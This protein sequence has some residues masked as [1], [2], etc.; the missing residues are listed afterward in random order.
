[1]AARDVE[2]PFSFKWPLAQPSSA[3][4]VRRLTDAVPELGARKDSPSQVSA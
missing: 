3:T 4:A 1:M 2:N